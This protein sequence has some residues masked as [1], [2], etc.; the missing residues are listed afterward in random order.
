[1]KA[2]S[3]EAQHATSTFILLF[4]A[5]VIWASINYGSWQINVSH[6]SGVYMVPV[7]ETYYSQWKDTLYQE[8]HNLLDE[9]LVQV[10]N[11]DKMCAKKF[12][13]GKY[14]GILEEEITNIVSIVH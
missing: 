7:Y 1:M 3:Y 5:F 13:C 11:Y 8:G 10:S 2:C 6:A 14:T 4:L 9:A 12:S